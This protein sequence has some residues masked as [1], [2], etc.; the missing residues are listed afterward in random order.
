MRPPPKKILYKNEVEL[1]VLSPVDGAAIFE[2]VQ[3][4]L[5]ELK[6][7]MSWAHRTG[8]IQEAYQIYGD[9]EAKTLRGEEANF[10]GFDPKSGD[11]LFCASLVPGSRLNERAFDIGYWVS[12]KKT[13][14]GLGTLA[15]KILTFL[16]FDYYKADRLSVFCNPDNGASR[17]VIENVG[18]HFEGTLRNFSVEPT[19]E[20]IKN[21]YSPVRDVLGYSLIPEDFKG[22]PWIKD[23]QKDLVTLS[24]DE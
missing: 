20:M 17:K 22:L 3:E 14:Q 6:T 15:A 24:T 13:R 5:S 9:F 21:G 16:A 23:L 12:S 11:F 2:G 4:S 10:A 8:D 19:L 1:R 7:F 18:F